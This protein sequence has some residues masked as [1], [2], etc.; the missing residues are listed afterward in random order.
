MK[1]TKFKGDITSEIASSFKNK[2]RHGSERKCW[3]II[4][5]KQ[6]YVNKEKPRPHSE[7]Q[8]LSNL[9]DAGMLQQIGSYTIFAM[10]R[11]Y[12]LEINF[13]LIA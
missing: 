3:P 2:A 5:L 10:C 12:V 6:R 1:I 11:L 13:H 8:R 4:N 7:G 9:L